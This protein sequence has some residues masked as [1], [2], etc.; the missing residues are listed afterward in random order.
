MQI[1]IRLI[2]PNNMYREEEE[3]GLTDALQMK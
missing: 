2:A 1:F 3:H